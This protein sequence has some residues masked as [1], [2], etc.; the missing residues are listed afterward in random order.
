MVN[1]ETLSSL[2]HSLVPATV[3]KG[4]ILYHGRTDGQIP[5]APDW[6][7][8][9]FEHANIFCRGPSYIVTLQAR[10]DLRLVYFDGSSA[11]KMMD[12]PLDSQDVILWGRPQPDKCHLERE[13]IKAL[14]DWGRP[15]G[16]DGFVR[17]EFHLCVHAIS[18][19][20]IT[21][22]A[23]WLQRGYDM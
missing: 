17:M 20:P 15:L 18:G 2:G 14:C 1:Q 7:A 11:A 10:R 9:D 12:G 13:R 5:N 3:P 21:L 22:S 16:L 8:F 19:F 6:L 4:T 23:D